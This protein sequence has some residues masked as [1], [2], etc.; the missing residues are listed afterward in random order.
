MVDEQGAGK[1][2]VEPGDADDGG[3]EGMG[4]ER[5]P[6]C[7]YGGGMGGGGRGGKG[8]GGKG[9]GWKGMGGGGGMGGEMSDESDAEWGQGMKAETPRP[10]LDILDER[11]ARGEIEKEEYIEKKTL[12]SQR[13]KPE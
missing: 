13:P 4:G 2:D 5:C 9:M 12:I 10:A 6:H 7:G 3:M 1:Q 11:F 8:M